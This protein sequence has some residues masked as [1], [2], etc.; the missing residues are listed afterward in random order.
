MYLIPKIQ[1]HF[2]ADLGSYDLAFCQFLRTPI[3]L[4]DK[5]YIETKL[6]CE[7]VSYQ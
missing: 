4:Q 7:N 1:V 6:I 3:I 2:R 5:K